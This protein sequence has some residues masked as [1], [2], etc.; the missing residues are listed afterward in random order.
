MA[1]IIVL[2]NQKGGVGKTTS[3]AALAAGL[4]SKG[5]KVLAVDLDPQGNL[6]F[7]LGLDINTHCT[8][9]EV[10]K[11]GIAIQEAIH[12]TETCDIIA[13]NILLSEAEIEF[14]REN[15]ETLLKERLEEVKDNYDFII[16]DTPPSLNILTL[17]AYA[18]SDYLI[19]PM[20]AEILSL[21]GLIQ[22]KETVEAVRGGVNPH[23]EILGILLTKYNKRT[24]LAAD[25]LEMAETVA[26]QT[27]TTLFQSKIRAGVAAAEAP[28]HGE[29]IFAY[30][31]R[32][33]P[34]RDYKAFIEEVL[35]RT[36]K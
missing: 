5:Y 18:A 24:R 31:P 3:T 25:V 30:A 17:N 1:V 19:I 11:G 13:S 7:S 27:K 29:N 16:I 21:V 32:S 2:T 8:I 4:G 6:G 14:Q 23:L 9:Y 12:Q 26:G 10:L 15:R 34:A 20:A 28:A 22:L 36:A 35:S 33:N